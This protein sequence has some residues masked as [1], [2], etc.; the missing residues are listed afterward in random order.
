MFQMENKRNGF[1]KSYS[2]KIVSMT[3]ESRQDSSHY[4]L[5]GLNAAIL[6]TYEV[7]AR[8]YTPKEF[9]RA[10]GYL[11]HAIVLVDAVLK[12]AIEVN[13]EQ[14]DVFDSI[15]KSNLLKIA[16]QISRNCKESITQA[17]EYRHHYSGTVSCHLELELALRRLLRIIMGS[18]TWSLRV[19][20]TR[21]LDIYYGRKPTCVC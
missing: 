8:P 10:A 13:Y 6:E 11:L 3:K 21:H 12:Y 17:G 14:E 16:K 19:L 2:E 9:D 15:D 20:A 4:A 1:W 7:M 18:A 5:W